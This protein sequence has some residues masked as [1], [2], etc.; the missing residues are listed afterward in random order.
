MKTARFFFIL[1]T[2]A[3]CARHVLPRGAHIAMLM[4]GGGADDAPSPVTDVAPLLN[5]A[6]PQQSA[7]ATMPLRHLRFSRRRRAA[8]PRPSGR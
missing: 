5:D 6:M 8:S 1:V 2:V 7:S 4:R 3:A